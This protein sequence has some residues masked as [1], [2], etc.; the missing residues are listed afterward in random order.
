MATKK[1]TDKSTRIYE[2]QTPDGLMLAADYEYKGIEYTQLELDIER[3]SRLAEVLEA[4]GLDGLLD[5]ADTPRIKL[6]TL[7]SGIAKNKAH[8]KL[9][10][11]LIQRKDGG[12]IPEGAFTKGRALMMWKL[13][14][15]VLEDFFTINAELTSGML[16][17]FLRMLERGLRAV[18]EVLDRLISSF[19]SQAET[20]QN[21]QPSAKRRSI[22]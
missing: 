4:V 6:G 21:K 5:F 1:A 14:E 13:L 8:D 10:R 3:M 20:L 19:I 12:D 2:M 11:V 16:D 7:L 9:L 22:K 15:A 17:S 18:P